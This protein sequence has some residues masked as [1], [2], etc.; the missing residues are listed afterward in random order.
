MQC[1]PKLVYLKHTTLAVLYLL[2]SDTVSFTATSL[3]VADINLFSPQISKHHL[4]THTTPYH[5]GT[6][7]L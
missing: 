2:F 6:G 3:H 4:H 7:T 1:I 5:L